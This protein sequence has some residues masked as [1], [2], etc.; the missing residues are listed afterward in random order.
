MEQGLQA[1]HARGK[2]VCIGVPPLGYQIKVDMVKHIN[3]GDPFSF[4]RGL[5]G[6]G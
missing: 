4:I 5:K 3:V 1:T 6:L 2:L